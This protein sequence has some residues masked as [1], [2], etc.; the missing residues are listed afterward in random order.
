MRYGDYEGAVAAYSNGRRILRDESLFAGELA[1]IHESLRE[2]PEAVEEYLVQL[3]QSPG[4][5]GMITTKIRGLMEDSED[6]DLIIEIVKK[7]LDR[8]PQKGVIYEVLGDLY[9]KWGKMDEALET[10]RTLGVG[11]NDDGASLYR[12]G[13]RCYYSR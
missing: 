6:P 12:F 9:I 10:F 7:G 8:S 13:E 11:A 5:V 3:N 2:Y 4:Q 1:A